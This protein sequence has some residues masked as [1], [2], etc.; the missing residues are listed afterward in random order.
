M[1]SVEELQTPAK[2]WQH[3]ELA[4]RAIMRNDGDGVLRESGLALAV[5]PHLAQAYLLQSMWWMRNSRYEEARDAA[6]KAQA[7]SPQLPWSGVL[8]AGALVEL[9]RDA[10]A[11]TVLDHIQTGE[12][13]SWQAS[14]E[15]ARAALALGHVEDALHWSELAMETAPVG[16]TQTRLVRANALTLAGHRVEAMAEMR[17]YLQEDQQG[18]RREQVALALRGSDA[19][20][21]PLI[22]TISGPEAAPVR[23]EPLSKPAGAVRA[24]TF[25]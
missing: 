20:G 23:P 17:T 13:R 24:S 19:A 15:R 1:V 14:Y 22:Q 16:C 5:Q 4:R 18:A 25:Q 10:E 3:L 12:A 8:L 21:E 6:A 7:I 2:A 11:L 9:R